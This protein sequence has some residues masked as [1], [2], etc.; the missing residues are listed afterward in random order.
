MDCSLSAQTLSGNLDNRL[1]G[2]YRCVS[3]HFAIYVYD[4]FEF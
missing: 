4:V 1:S 3:E 2:N